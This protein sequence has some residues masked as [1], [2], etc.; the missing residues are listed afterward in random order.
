MNDVPWT[1]A[2]AIGS[3]AARQTWALA[4]RMHL[5]DI[6]GDYH[7]V[8]PMSDLAD[9]VQQRSRIRTTQAMR[10]WID[11]VLFRV[12]SECVDRREPLLGALVVDQSGR[13]GESYRVAVEEL[14]RER[15]GDLDEHAASERLDCYRVFGATL[16]PGGGEPGPLPAPAVPRVRASSGPHGRARNS[17]SAD[18]Q[19]SVRAAPR[20]A[21]RETAPPR[22]CDR[23]F[24]EMP[25][26]GICD[27][28]G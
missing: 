12:M 3:E 23:C 22:V 9:F 10:H 11:D 26:S 21:A 15:I 27:N 1:N 6:A 13:V 8:V 24:L 16:P 18:G 28:C 25:V 7:A 2:A 14:R 19:R 17:T 5:A 20:P 4:A